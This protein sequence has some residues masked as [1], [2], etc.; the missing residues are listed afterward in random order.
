MVNLFTYLL[1]KNKKIYNSI[2]KK[3]N[4]SPMRVYFLAH[5]SKAKSDKDYRIIERLIKMQLVS[6]WRIGN[7]TV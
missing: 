4:A 5:G 2:A 6:G 1:S 7:D 3:E